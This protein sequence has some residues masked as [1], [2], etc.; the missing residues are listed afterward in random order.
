MSFAAR[1]E[2]NPAS[3]A[4][5]PAAISTESV[6]VTCGTVFA[7][8]AENGDILPR[9]Y[10][11]FYAHDTRFLSQFMVTVN[12]KRLKNTGH[13]TFEDRLASFYCTSGPL[14]IVRD[15][16]VSTA[17]HE[18]IAVT[19]HVSRPVEVHLEISL[20]A[21][22]ADVFEVRRG[23][24]RK[25]GETA[26]VCSIDDEDFI[27]TYRRGKYLRETR[28][29]FSM[30]AKI[31]GNTAHFDF[32]LKPKAVWKTCID[33]KPVVD[34][35]HFASYCV[36]EILGKPFEASQEQTFLGYLQEVEA[37]MPLENIPAIKTELRELQQAYYRAVN[38]LRALRLKQDDGCYVL[39]AGLPWFMA[40][41]G[42]DSIISAIQTRL[43]GPEL[44][45]GTLLTLGRLQAL[46]ADHF[47]EAEPGKIIHE[48]RRGELSIF[49]QVPHTRYYGTIDATPLFIILLWEAYQW[50]GEK[51]L[52][53]DMLPAAELALEWIDRYGDIDNDGFV[54][55]RRRISKGLINQ[56]WKD[57]HDS[58]SFDNGTL[59]AGPI[60]L[61]EVQGYVY[62]ARLSLA[63][64]YETLGNPERAE[65]LKMSAEQLKTRF[66][67][68]FWMPDKNFYAVALD[69]RKQ[70]VDS[71]ASNPGHC[72]WTGIVSEDK[73]A[74]V[75]SRLM[76]PDMFSGWG[77]RTLSTEARRYNPLSYH[78]GSVWPHDNSIIAAGMNRYGFYREASQIAMALVEATAIMPSHTLPELFAG[79]PRR[80]YSFPVP[81][82]AANSPQAWA[83]G[84]II[85]L[86]EALLGLS[87]VER[88]LVSSPAV[89]AGCAFS[90]NGVLF[91]NRR[92]NL[93]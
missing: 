14:N 13:A 29:K 25:T 78:N 58:I 31:T 87:T 83:S 26:L 36:A 65:R 45:T 16:F 55:Y 74:K 9:S 56:G 53:E 7:V 34:H 22:F 70:Q 37:G 93:P 10:Q 72:L 32:K 86:M 27:L 54:E 42:R 6:R 1:N 90:L 66:N 60:A 41:F 52:L 19:S 40:V 21:D 79:Y 76:A 62:A 11:G 44:M 89:K 12:G 18:D 47:R 82:P 35:Q 24:V 77:I 15:R 33:V 2:Q 85:F 57:S 75:V 23:K 84:S 51:K 88:R 28:I 20:E 43:L 48:V 30:P 71:I 49:D 46:E 59:A 38:D 81:Y 80:A 61:A 50:T 8:S 64:V 63:A 68:A 91:R 17:F 67:A 4:L 39:A 92:V 5:I 69:G 3:Y 73:A